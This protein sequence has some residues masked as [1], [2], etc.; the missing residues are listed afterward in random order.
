MNYLKKYR[1]DAGLTKAPTNENALEGGAFND[2]T[3]TKETLAYLNGMMKR[4]NFGAAP[5]QSG[6]TAV[7]QSQAAAVKTPVRKTQQ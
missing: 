6:R 3:P 2:C 7:S 1:K 4:Q 5:M